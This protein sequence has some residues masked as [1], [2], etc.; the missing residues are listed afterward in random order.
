M[1]IR[2]R[3]LHIQLLG[4][5]AVQRALHAIALLHGKAAQPQALAGPDAA[6]RVGAVKVV[7]PGRMSWGRCSG[8]HAC[9]R[10]PT[11]AFLLDIHAGIAIIVVVVVVVHHGGIL[12]WR[13]VRVN[14]NIVDDRL[15][16]GLVLDRYGLPD[17][18]GG[19]DGAR[20]E[21]QSLQHALHGGGLGKHERGGGARQQWSLRHALQWG[22]LPK[23]RGREGSAAVRAALCGWPR[24]WCGVGGGVFVWCWLGCRWEGWDAVGQAERVAACGLL[25]VCGSLGDVVG[26][27]HGELGDGGRDGHHAWWCGWAVHEVIVPVYLAAAVRRVSSQQ[28]PTW[29]DIIIILLH[30]IIAT[31]LSPGAESVCVTMAVYRWHFCRPVP[32]RSCNCCARIVLVC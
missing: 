4:H 24:A 23:G 31:N 32:V 25:T 13:E 30:R 8:V 12:Q 21:L 5:D 17:D 6:Q 18:L 19:G 28:E 2:V 7:R 16:R 20:W 11:R 3:V 27:A 15:E 14:G 22:A 1:I 9:R 29:G 10:Q 26:T